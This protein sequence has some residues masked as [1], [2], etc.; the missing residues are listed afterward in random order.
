MK[1]KKKKLLCENA[2]WLLYIFGNK[3][4]KIILF[5]PFLFLLDPCHPGPYQVAQGGTVAVK[6][7]ESDS[8]PCLLVSGESKEEQECDGKGES[9]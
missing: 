4:P 7:L 6:V 2:F 3:Y 8:F 9:Q 5:E 1:E